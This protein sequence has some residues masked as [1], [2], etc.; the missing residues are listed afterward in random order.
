MEGDSS[1]SPIRDLVLKFYAAKPL[2]SPGAMNALDAALRQHLRD[3]R[4]GLHVL[5]ES[6][7]DRSEGTPLDSLSLADGLARVAPM[8]FGMCAANLVGAYDGV[9]AFLQCS[10]K[11]IPPESNLLTV[12]VVDR[13]VVEGTP[14][15]EWARKLFTA[16]VEAIPLR[17][18]QARTRAEFDAKNMIRERGSTKAVGV[19]LKHALP[20]L[21]W[22]NFFGPEYLRLLGPERLATAPAPLVERVGEGIL[23]GLGHDP[24]AWNSAEYRRLE[25][26]VLSHLGREYFFSKSDPGGPTKAPVFDARHDV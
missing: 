13:D 23:I 7:D 14:L 22:L 10:R 15:V 17:Y 25:Q 9:T 1:V 16:V 19:N 21:Y 2:S 8:R 3:W 12:E 18:G 20:G 6:Q 11:G 5:P 4:E 26:A 24:G